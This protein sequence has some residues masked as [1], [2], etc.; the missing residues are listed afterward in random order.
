[1]SAAGGG[2]LPGQLHSGR[3]QPSS[4]V[5]AASFGASLLF[6][7][8]VALSLLT[9]QFNADH[10]PALPWF[11]IPVLAVVFAVAWW[12]D[13]RWEIGLRTPCRAPISL[14]AAFAIASNIAAHAVWVLEKA[15][16]GV[17]YSAPSGPDDVTLFFSV[18]YWV[19]ISV[20]LS[21][22]SEVC[23]R[24][25]MQTQLSRHLSIGLAVA[26]VITF[27]T[28]AHP[29]ETLWLRFFG[30]L[31][32]LAAWGWLREIG[33][34]LRA[35]IV[36][37]IAAVMIGDVIFWLTGPVDFGGFSSL[38]NSIVAGIGLLALGLSVFL[39]G[40]IVSYAKRPG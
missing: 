27:N 38:H 14:I 28:F 31:A 30:V 22:S 10:Q 29:W 7:L 37:H 26:I 36:T 21:T 5:L 2:R 33:G 19:A 6:M 9:A 23:F 17:T 39:S 1:M 13:R 18:T 24:G 8:L 4:I 15:W 3:Y 16:K 12:C 34:S 40:R 25:I 20:A 35:C 32:I 11:P